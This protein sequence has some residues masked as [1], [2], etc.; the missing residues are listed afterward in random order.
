MRTE[1]WGVMAR[2]ATGYSIRRIEARDEQAVLAMVNAD[3]V[4]GQPLATP[5]ML[6]EALAGQSSVDSGWWTELGDL[7]TEVATTRTGQVMGVLSYATRPR[8]GAGVIMWLHGGE[9]RRVID[10]L[11]DHVLSRLA[12]RPVEAFSFATALGLGMEA[13]P[14]RHRQVT[15]AALT[16]RGFLGTDLWRYM[17]ADLPITGLPHASY[18]VS[19]DGDRRTLTVRDDDT[20]LGEATIGLPVQG[21]GVLWWISVEPAARGRGLGK[22]LLGSALDLLSGLGAQQ[23]ILYVD[24]DEP[25]GERDR[26]AANRL[27]EQAGFIEVD[28]LLSYRRPR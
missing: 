8:D 17:R 1:G 7:T 20:L 28:R 19:S 18:A 6:A 15:V 5:S 4:P 14:V 25:G 22:A 2:L 10:T 26:T 11:L 16:D 13:L 3:Q 27:Y 24:D 9:D 23:V 12:E 21:I